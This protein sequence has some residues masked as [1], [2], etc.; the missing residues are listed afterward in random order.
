MF[1]LKTV[2]FIF[3]FI[4]HILAEPLKYVRKED[5]IAMRILV[6][7]KGALRVSLLPVSRET[8]SCRFSKQVPIQTAKTTPCRLQVVEWAKIFQTTP[9]R[10]ANQWIVT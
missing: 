10:L 3:Y 4:F 8:T 6:N 2:V 9:C 5:I 1:F 7:K